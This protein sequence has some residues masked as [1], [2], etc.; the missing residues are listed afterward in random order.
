MSTAAPGPALTPAILIVDD[1]PAN[2]R[3]YQATLGELGAELYMAGSGEEALARCG[4]RPYAMIL[5]DVHLSGMSGFEVAQSIRE[6]CSGLDAPIVFVSAVYVH[7]RDTYR[8]YRLGAVDYILS[9]VVP[10]ILRAKAAVFIRLHRMRLEAQQQAEAIERAYRD[11]RTVHAEMEGF[12]Y[13]VSHDL[14]TPLGQ[15]A[16]FA[17]LMQMGHAGELT[18]KSREYL[19]YI[20]GAAQRMNALIDDMLLLGNMTRTE[21]QVQGV[22]L[23]HLAETELK[24]LAEARPHANAHVHVQTGLHARGDQRL[25]RVALANLLSNAWKYS[26]GVARPFVEFGCVDGEAGPTFFVRDNGAG[27]D[28][29][30]AGER[31]FRP[32]QRFHSDAAFPGNGVGLAI[33]QRVIDK[34]GGRLWAESAPGRGATFFFTLGRLSSM[35]MP[36]V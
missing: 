25:L 8:G 31:L 22:D 36:L 10:E 1:N 4:E 23:S 33:V 9:P 12:S 17:D 26:A 30:A 35:P 6:Q 15:I 11:L 13:S 19:G 29:R 2:R 5:L 21:M 24:S 3:L 27:F 28:V 16:G 32:F 20:Q 34:H 7:E 18:E 14:R